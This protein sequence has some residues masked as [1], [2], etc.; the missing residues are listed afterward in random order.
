MPATV[1]KA[2]ARSFDSPDEVRTP[3]L[4]RVETL[5]MGDYTLGRFTFQPGWTWDT[6]IKPVAGTDSCQAEHVGFATAGEIEVD[7]DDGAHMHIKAGDA[8]TIP[9]GHHA[10]VIGDEAFSGIE[11]KS[12]ATYAKS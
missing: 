3:S 8:Y 1:T 12:A 7:T 5:N 2:E 6:C 11:F 10:K 9:P 4:S